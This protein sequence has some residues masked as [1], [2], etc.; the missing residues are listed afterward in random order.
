M[1]HFLKVVLYMF[2]S[3]TFC[4]AQSWQG[5]SPPKASQMLLLFL[6]QIPLVLCQLNHFAHSFVMLSNFSPNSRTT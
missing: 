4:T 1:C 6:V 3:L 5:I 2:C